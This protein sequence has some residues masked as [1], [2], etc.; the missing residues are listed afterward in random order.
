MQGLRK[1]LL[2]GKDEILLN[3]DEGGKGVGKF[4]AFF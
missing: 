1:F 4:T 3:P 2:R